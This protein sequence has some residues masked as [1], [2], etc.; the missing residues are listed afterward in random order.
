[1]SNSPHA[2]IAGAVTRGHGRPSPVPLAPSASGS[3]WR[4]TM[5]FISTPAPAPGR[6]PPLRS[7]RPVRAQADLQWSPPHR[8]PRSRLRGSRARR[9]P[10]VSALKV[11]PSARDRR[12]RWC[13]RR[14]PGHALR[15][16]EAPVSSASPRPIELPTSRARARSRHGAGSP[17]SRIVDVP[18]RAARP[19]PPRRTRAVIRDGLA[20]GVLRCAHR[21]RASRAGRS[22]LARVKPDATGPSTVQ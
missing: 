14:R 12:R 9:G 21:R 22:H 11:R 17:A 15:C 18:E 7:V 10:F 13:Q 20:V 5:R 4:I 8:L 16:V 2:T 19:V 1:M 3:R 6:S